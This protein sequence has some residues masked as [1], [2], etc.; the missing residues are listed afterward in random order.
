[1]DNESWSFS[2]V[3]SNPN[4]FSK[5]TAGHVKN[6]S[7]QAIMT[8]PSGRQTS[9]SLDTN[10]LLF[11]LL[12]DK[13]D[14]LGACQLLSALQDNNARVTNRNL[15]Q[16]LCSVA[17]DSFNFIVASR[18]YAALGDLPLSI[19]AREIH[20]R[21]QNA[22]D[23]EAGMTHD[24]MNL[25][26]QAQIAL[27]NSD[28]D[29]YDG[30][31]MSCGRIDEVLTLYKELNLYSR[32]EK[33]C[34][35]SMINTLRTEAIQWLINSG[36]MTTAGMLLAQRG[37]VR[38]ALDLL[39]Q[40]RSYLSAFELAKR[41]MTSSADPSLAPIIELLIGKLEDSHH[42]SQAAVLCTLGSG[43]NH[44]RALALF[45]KSHAFDEALELARQHLP[46]ECLP[47]EREWAEWLFQTGQYDKATQHYLECM[48]QEMAVESAFRANNFK[49]V[50]SLL[51]DIP[52][53][54]T[55][56][57]LCFRLAEMKYI[58]GDAAGAATWL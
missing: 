27:L 43:R 50:E 32:A 22:K 47:I 10:L 3:K 31:M 12:L 40:D 49:L 57:H 30:L 33:I 7:V 38:G 25:Y 46:H 35:E 23:G 4:N 28:L 24:R 39:I 51:M 37:D 16:K 2:Y 18:C 53:A 8:T 48:N 42:Y 26:C 11:N 56:A 6:I 54:E 34:P 13:H 41:A 52:A 15:W 36:Q 55:N 14:I 44:E 5:I 1:M 29:K 20:E 9:V 21:V 19:T 45:R 17:L 58:S